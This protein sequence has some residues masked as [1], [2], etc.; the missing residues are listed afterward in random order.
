MGYISNWRKGFEY[1]EKNEDDRARRSRTRG[2]LNVPRKPKE[3]CLGFSWTLD[4][5]KTL[6][7]TTIAH[8]TEH[9]SKKF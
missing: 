2:D 4:R 1:P 7:Q 6:E 9:K 3:K 8:Q 5:P